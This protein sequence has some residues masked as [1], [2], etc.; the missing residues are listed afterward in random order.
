MEE[1]G[2][3]GGPTISLGDRLSRVRASLQ[4]SEY[5]ELMPPATERAVA[6]FEDRFALQLPPMFRAFT[7]EVGD[8]IHSEDGDHFLFGLD[9]IALEVAA[10]GGRPSQPFW[11]TNEQTSAFLDA[12]QRI[13]KDGS[14]WENEDLSELQK[15][16]AL[17]GCLTVADHG[18]A[19]YS[20]LVVTGEQAGF[21][22]R[23]GEIDVPDI[24]EVWEI[25]LRGTGTTPL[26]FLSW[27][28]LYA[29]I[30]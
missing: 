26:D 14:V 20:V 23:T 17:D 18:C 3:A 21:M 22:W 12:M 9:R 29:G 19:D 24:R 16:G 11:Y 25:E 27:L 1:S 10:D 8:G 28:E 13:P 7:L 5:L 6:D 4:E 15:I 2:A 30:R